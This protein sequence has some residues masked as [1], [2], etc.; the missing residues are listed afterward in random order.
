V[1]S[2]TSDGSGVK[3]FQQG[4]PLPS[5]NV[6]V[7]QASGG[8]ARPTFYVGDLPTGDIPGQGRV[9]KWS[10]GMPAWQQIVPGPPVAGQPV[11]ALARRFY[12]DPYR[13][14][15]LYLVDMG[16]VLRSDTRGTTWVVD[17]PLE[18]AVTENGAFPFE[19]PGD[20]N[21]GQALI[22]DM[23][24]DPHRPGT[25]FAIGPAGVFQTLDGRRWTALIRSSA[26]AM[27]PNNGVYDFVSCPRALYVATSNRG[28]LRLSPVTPDWD[29]PMDGLQAAIGRI[30]L[31]RVH[32]KGSGYGPPDDELDAEA[33]VWLDTEPE[34]A[35]GLQLR[36]NADQPAASGML[37]L[38][39]DAFNRGRRIR[40]EFERSGCRT[41]R[42]VRVIET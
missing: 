24:F 1:T 13:P 4:P 33:I 2:A 10:A 12:V 36:D 26:M 17:G 21:P 25:R 18:L 3:A 22:R 9:W 39:R 19:S 8:H 40:L 28:L 38:L 20:G 32:D 23:L 35:F 15:Q 42:I 14:S 29:Y 6:T 7:V 41:G 30:T 34:K 37:D 16:H 11:P 27:R 5:P 31:L